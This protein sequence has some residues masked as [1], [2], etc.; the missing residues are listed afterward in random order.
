MWDKT[1]A[2][3]EQDKIGLRDFLTAMIPVAGP[4]MFKAKKDKKQEESYQ[5]WLSDNMA[6]SDPSE[7]GDMGQR[8]QERMLNRTGGEL[9]TP[10]L[11][12]ATMMQREAQDP[13]NMGNFGNVAMRTA[14]GMAAAGQTGAGANLAALAHK[15][16]QT[17]WKPSEGGADIENFKLPDGTVVAATT[18][19]EKVE[20]IRKG[21]VKAGVASGEKEVPWSFASGAELGLQGRE[22][23]GSFAIQRNPD[24]TIKEVKS[25]G[26]MNVSVGGASVITPTDVSGTII[27]FGN[28][29]K[30][31]GAAVQVIDDL[32]KTLDA[33]PGGGITGWSGVATDFVG[34]VMNLAEFTAQDKAI[35]EK[36]EAGFKRFASKYFPTEDAAVAQAQVIELAYSLARINNMGT[37]GGGR[38]IT[39]A[40]MQ[41][42]LKQLGTMSKVSDFK[43]VLEYQRNKIIGNLKLDK[44]VTGSVLKTAGHDESVLPMDLYNQIVSPK[45]KKPLSEY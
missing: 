43:S 35:G 5:K 1:L 17:P 28:S 26:G 36:Y 15:Q 27:N 42:A 16:F 20:L 45:A 25:L 18:P 7:L 31:A 23:T 38:G 6:Y 9:S 29:I 12:A 24:G 21:G 8:V 34:K 14:T 33:N 22:A 10:G 39:D 13:G 41:Y 44:A 32:T 40:D 37:S 4:F 11:M 30:G 19:Q 3:P 2:D